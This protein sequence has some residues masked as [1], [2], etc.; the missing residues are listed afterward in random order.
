ME[1]GQV[2]GSWKGSDGLD[3]GSFG[4]P[5]RPLEAVRKQR[6]ERAP[7]PMPPLY[8]AWPMHGLGLSYT[9]RVAKAQI[10]DHAGQGSGQGP[11]VA[12]RIFVVVLALVIGTLAGA[13]CG[14]RALEQSVQAQG[15]KQWNPTEQRDKPEVKAGR[16]SS[17]TG[18]RRSPVRR[19][20]L[21]LPSVG[22]VLGRRAPAPVVV[23]VQAPAPQ[24]VVVPATSPVV[25]APAVVAAP[26]PVAVP[27][28]APIFW[29]PSPQASPE[30]LQSGW[31]P[32]RIQ[33]KRLRRARFR[34]TLTS[35]VLGSLP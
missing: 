31:V 16:G 26:G 20:R 33:L 4:I 28:V 8:V 30:P 19:A 27:T 3:R 21:R 14:D 35:A 10:K 7:L 12:T 6:A 25:A 9:A 5:R 23:E 32:T 13:G 2:C 18:A 34:S 17:S 11:C 24:V 29:M 22:R 15:V 1:R